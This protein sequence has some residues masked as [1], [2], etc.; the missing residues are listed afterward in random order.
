MPFD[1]E[2]SSLRRSNLFSELSDEDLVHVAARLR[3]KIFPAKTIIVKEGGPGDSMFI[4]KTG[5]V[6]VRRREDGSGVDRFITTLR[7]GDCF[8]EIGLL[9]GR[10]RAATVATLLTTEVYML[11]HDDIQGLMR[12]S[13]SIAL[14]IGRLINRIEDTAVRR[15]TETVSLLNLNIQSELLASTPRA[16]LIEHQM[17]PISLSSNR[18]TVAMVNPNDLL[19]LDSITRFIKG[20]TVQPVRITENDFDSFMNSIYPKL[21]K[22][23]SGQRPDAR[24]TYFEASDSAVDLSAGLDLIEDRGEITGGIGELEKEAGHAPIIRLANSIIELALK[25]SASDI[26]L[27][28]M[29][30]GVRLRYRVDGVLQ[31]EKVLPRKVHLPLASRMKILSRLDITERRL[32]QDGRI[33]LKVGERTV[34]FRVSTMPSKYGEKIVIRILDKEAQVFGLDKL[35]TYEPTLALVRQM[36]RKPYGIIYVTGPTGSGKTTTLYSALAELNSPEV[37]IL[38]AEDPIEYELPGITQVQVNPDIGLDFA[39]VIRSFLRQDPDIILVGETRDRETA[40]IAVQAALTGHVVLTTVHT[41]DAPSTF[42]RLVEMGIEPFLVSTSLVGI[43]AQR[44]VRKICPICKEP[45]AADQTASRFL[46][47]REGSTVYKGTGC[48]GC[49]HSG[50]V[51]RAGVYE[52]LLANEEIRHMVAENAGTEKIRERAIALG[53]KTLKE[54]ASILLTQGITTVD[55]VLRTVAVDS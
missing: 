34:D 38:T 27:E 33:S 1:D 20:S 3:Q 47:L 44:L 8:G 19:G 14:S 25:R 11:G 43:V 23:L 5:E 39:R 52:V 24:R 4:I 50:F 26:H 51:G 31:E 37:N 49:N 13:P 17:V 21:T 18:L 30:K 48:D 15:G 40:R 16:F 41:N 53:M 46:G 55:E 29:E 54:Y 7:D 28:P 12:E 22:T 36:I 10:P 42:V 6:Q 32:P 35:I 9:T 2:V 45:F